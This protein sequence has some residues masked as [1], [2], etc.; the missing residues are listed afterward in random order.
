MK[1]FRFFFLLLFLLCISSSYSQVRNEYQISFDNAVHGWEIPASTAT[2]LNPGTGVAV[3]I[4]ASDVTL[5]FTGALR[6][7]DVALS[8]AHGGQTNSGWHLVG[9]PFA[10]TLDWNQVYD[11]AGNTGVEPVAYVFDASAAYSGT[12]SGYNAST[13]MTVNSGSENIA[14]GQAFFIQK[15]LAFN[16]SV[17]CLA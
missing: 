16:K 7:S 17:L 10:A 11:D 2:A 15:G 1:S 4:G 9:N 5:D 14:S 12:Y 13:D 3:Q 8:L 6:S